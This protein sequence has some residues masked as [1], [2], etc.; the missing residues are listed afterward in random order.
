M[1]NYKD[2]LNKDIIDR[3]GTIK[4]IEGT[5]YKSGDTV[6]IEGEKG[7]I[8][9]GRKM[10]YHYNHNNKPSEVY[11]AI[12]YTVELDNGQ[13]L[14]VLEDDVKIDTMAYIKENKK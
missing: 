6:W 4:D 10:S 13:I 3:V 14:E 8:L 1:S 9:K 7:K 12:F 11:E 2:L 5:K